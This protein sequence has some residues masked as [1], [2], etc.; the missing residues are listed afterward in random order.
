MK[1]TDQVINSF[2]R[3][4]DYN[5]HS[6]YSLDRQQ[7]QNTII[8]HI[9]QQKCLDY[10]TLYDNNTNQQ[11]ILMAGC[12]GAGKSTISKKLFH[13]SHLV[14][15]IDQIRFLLYPPPPL[16]TTTEYIISTQREAGCV[17]EL[18]V[19]LGLSLKVPTVIDASLADINWQLQYIQQ[20][21]TMFLHLNIIIL[22]ITAIKEIVY[23]RV[24][25][26]NQ[27]SHQI[28]ED[29]SIIED[30][31]QRLHDLH[32]L[33][34]LL[35]HIQYLISLDNSRHDAFLPLIKYPWHMKW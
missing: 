28:V 27:Q 10:S 26:R 14:I 16:L 12:I 6:Q 32:Q 9:F 3:Y 7:H 19:L 29:V 31:Y 8:Q 22:H 15:D 11:L 25:R 30:S 5:Y 20:L 21:K 17:A 2:R 33:Q 13:H 35:P 23:E 34:L 4:L 18:L 24:Y 1:I